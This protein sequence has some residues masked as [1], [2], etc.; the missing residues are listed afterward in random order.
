MA[1]L[2]ETR[3]ATNVLFVEVV[4]RRNQYLFNTSLGDKVWAFSLPA[5]HLVIVDSR[6]LLLAG[7]PR[8]HGIVL[9]DVVELFKQNADLSCYFDFDDDA[10]RM[11]LRDEY[12]CN[13][14]KFNNALATIRNAAALLPGKPLGDLALDNDYALVSRFKERYLVPRSIAGML[15]I[16]TTSACVN[17]YSRSKTGEI[18]KIMLRNM[19]PC[20]SAP[21]LALYRNP[22]AA[23]TRAVYDETGSSK[24]TEAV[25]LAQPS[26]EISFMDIRGQDAEPVDRGRPEPGINH[27]FDLKVADSWRPK[28]KKY[29]GTQGQTVAMMTVD[30]VRDLLLG[31]KMTPAAGLVMLDF[32]TRHNLLDIFDS[33]TAY[34]RR[35]LHLCSHNLEFQM[36]E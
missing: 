15:G 35:L 23:L 22:L 29:G 7:G 33:E 21:V 6:P 5:S 1:T 17:I 2:S 27:I 12:C 18:N 8:P 30:E 19:A 28:F 20:F 16:V 4:N 9:P 36:G 11:Q 24:T 34:L 31:Q 25:G 14:I 32:F 10:R 3:I 13:A 26:G